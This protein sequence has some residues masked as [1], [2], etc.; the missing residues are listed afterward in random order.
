MTKSLPCQALELPGLRTTWTST[1]T[2]TDAGII[3]DQAM[4]PIE[5]SG[6]PVAG[7]R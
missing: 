5:V 1:T 4:I 7:L 3:Q 2:A 6:L